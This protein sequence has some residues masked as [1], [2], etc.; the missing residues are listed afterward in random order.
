MDKHGNIYRA[1]EDEILETD[2][3]R[4][5]GYLTAKAEQGEIERYRQRFEEE[6]SKVKE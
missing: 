1:S 5:E 4:L 3:A 2:K 6:L